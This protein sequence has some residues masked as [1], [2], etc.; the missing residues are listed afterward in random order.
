MNP[1]HL[2]LAATFLTLYAK[3]CIKADVFLHTEC[4]AS[5]ERGQSELPGVLSGPD[6]KHQLGG[7]RRERRLVF[8]VSASAYQRTRI[9]NAATG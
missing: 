6:I 9:F 7:G 5:F 8:G 4:G 1:G 2:P 3:V